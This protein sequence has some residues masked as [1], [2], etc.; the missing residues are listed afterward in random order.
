MDGSHYGLITYGL[1]EGLNEEVNVSLRRQ[2]AVQFYSGGNTMPT[3]IA[4]IRL[5]VRISNELHET[6]ERAVETQGRTMTD[7]IAS[8]IQDA[9]QRAIEQSAV[10]RLSLADQEF[11]ASALLSPPKP[12]PVLKRAFARR[13]KLLHV[14]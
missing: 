3:A 2:Y 13:K 6:L 4:T 7:F 8:A 5:E 1:Q 14:E 10:I 12:T 11:F 9:A